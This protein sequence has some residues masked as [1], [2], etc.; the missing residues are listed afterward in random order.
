[1]FSDEPSRDQASG[2][3]SVAEFL[4]DLERTLGVGVIVQSIEDG[5][6]FTIRALLLLGQHSEHVVGEGRT[7]AEAYR[8][9]ARSAIAWRTTNDKQVPWWGGGA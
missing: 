8:A 7:E 1:M 5:P 4:E 3:D 2:A 9:L 6:T